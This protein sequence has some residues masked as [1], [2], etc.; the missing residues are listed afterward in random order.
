M[1]PKALQSL[2][3][4]GPVF[5]K[6]LWYLKH[7]LSLYYQ[8]LQCLT[9]LDTMKTLITWKYNTRSDYTDYEFSF[10]E[11]AS[12]CPA[13]VCCAVLSETDKDHLCQELW[14]LCPLKFTSRK[15][16]NTSVNSR[17]SSFDGYS[18]RRFLLSLFFSVEVHNGQSRHCPFCALRHNILLL[19]LS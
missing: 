13:W 15:I 9:V 19:G 11:V 2:L 8:S 7:P 18:S 6:L 14:W 16:C 5:G 12:I 1:V 10:M 17:V 3:L 4:S